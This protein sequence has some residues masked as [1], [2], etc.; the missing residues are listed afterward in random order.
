[1]G[2]TVCTHWGSKGGLIQYCPLPFPHS[3]FLS[4]PLLLPSL[5]SSSLLFLFSSKSLSLCPQ[6]LYLDSVFRPISGVFWGAWADLPLGLQETSPTGE[7]VFICWSTSVGTVCE[8]LCTSC[9]CG[10]HICAAWGCEHVFI[11]II[12]MLSASRKA[13]SPLE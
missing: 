5:V 4:F 7:C 9:I 1:M 3:S 10:L 2:Y 6:S 12:Y 8:P 11:V 13:A